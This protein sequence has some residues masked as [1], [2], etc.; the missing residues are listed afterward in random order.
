MATFWRFFGSCI[1]SEP[2]AARFR[3]ALYIYTKATPCVEVWQTSDLRPL[4]LG[5]EKRRRRKK[6]QGKNITA[7]LL[8]RAA[9]KKKKPQGKNIMSA[10]SVRRAAI[11]KHKNRQKY[12]VY[13]KHV[14]KCKCRRYHT[15]SYPSTKIMW[16]FNIN[17]YYSEL[18]NWCLPNSPVV[19][20]QT[21]D[22]FTSKQT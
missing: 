20:A 3:P 2:R 12:T 19:S 8:H 5:E 13:A 14:P 22:F 7:P 18:K 10:S 15:S 17:Y 4:R 6:L 11:I 1:S 9:I 16:P 21:V